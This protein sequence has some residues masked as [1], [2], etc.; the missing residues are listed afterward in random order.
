MLR[1]LLLALALT[2]A[3]LPAL[4]LE[5]FQTSELTVQTAG[6]PQ[7]FRIELALTAAQMEQGLMFRRT[8]A[9]DA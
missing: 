8:L 1:R 6:G 2:L 4:A 9:P 3:A 5:A 7:K